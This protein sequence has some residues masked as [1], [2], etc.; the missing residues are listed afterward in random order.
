MMRASCRNGCVRG[1]AHGYERIG[2]PGKAGGGGR[3]EIR[4][5]R[6]Q[7]ERQRPRRMAG[8][9]R[10]HGRAQAHHRRGR[11]RS[12]SRDHH[13]SGRQPKKPG[14][15]VREHQGP[16]RASR[17]LQHDRLQPVAVLPDDRRGADGSSAQSGAG[18]AEE[19]GPHHE[20]QGGARPRPRSATRTSSPATRSTSGNSR[21]SA[22]GR[23]TAGFISAP[24]TRW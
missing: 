12:R 11:S 18:A 23:S 19:D 21:R 22:C 17:A 13:L 2:R 14:A 5:D 9:G 7:P 4:S 1:N 10:R 16:S 24:A 15:A 8:Q 3:S 20:A 6:A